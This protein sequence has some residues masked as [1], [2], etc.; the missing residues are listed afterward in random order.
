VISLHQA[1]VETAIAT[2]GTAIAP[3]HAE[4]VARYCSRVVLVFDSD[5][6]GQNA[7]E[8]G[9]DV[10]LRKGLDVSV[11]R[12]PDGEDPDTFVQRFGAKEFEGRVERSVSFLEFRARMLK[13]SGDFDAPERAAEAVRSI[14]ST[15]AL[16]P[17]AL[18]RELYV[19]KIAGDYHLSETLLANELARALGAKTSGRRRELLPRD[20]PQQPEGSVPLP[21]E[22]YAAPPEI[23]GSAVQLVRRRPLVR[24]ELP[25]DEMQLLAVLLEGDPQMLEHV[26]ARIDPQ[27]F[28]H[29]LIRELVELVLAH[30]V[31][32]RSFSIDE[33]VMEDLPAELRDLV[34]LLAI[35]RESISTYWARIDVDVPEPNPWRIARDCLVRLLQ[36][37]LTREFREY[38][39]RTRNVDPRVKPEWEDEVLGRIR[40]LTR[41]IETLKRTV[42]G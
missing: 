17:D 9:I 36:E 26:F 10:L 34:T 12:L 35:D 30:Y 2:C 13:N 14:V 6:A 32:Q 33:I 3:E 25:A 27:D 4:L 29:P 7:T 20:R 41:E 28:S 19:Q 24:A 5:R 39:E 8:R 42:S 18:K 11:L 15:I 16:V 38:Q 23:D 31:N 22:P 40:E 37:R 21:P 1:G